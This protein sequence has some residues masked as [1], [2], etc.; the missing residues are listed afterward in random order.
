MDGTE[1]VASSNFSILFVFVAVERCL[2]SRCLAHLNVLVLQRYEGYT[3][4]HTD[5]WEGFMTYAVE[6]C[7]GA[8]IH[9]PSSIKTSSGIQKLRGIQRQDGDRISLLYESRP[10]NKS[11]LMRSPCSMSALLRNGSVSTFLRQWIHTHIFVGG[12]CRVEGK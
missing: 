6:M 11:R 1:N 2:P 7:S 12:A 5:W 4:R 9:I 10:K 3:Y 8:M